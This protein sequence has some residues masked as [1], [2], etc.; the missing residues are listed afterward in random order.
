MKLSLSGSAQ[1]EAGRAESR[2][3]YRL[4]GLDSIALPRTDPSEHE[5]PSRGTAGIISG[6]SI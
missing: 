6:L 1:R 2:S 4:A 5:P 3:T